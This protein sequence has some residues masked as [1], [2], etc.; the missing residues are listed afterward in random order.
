MDKYTIQDFHKQFPD[1]DACLD[2]LFRRFY[3]NGVICEKCDRETKHYKTAGRPSYQCEFC[4]NHVHPMA[5]TIFE[6]ST[7][8]L[9]LWFYGMYLMAQ[10]RCG[11]SAKQL[12]REL[13]VTYKTAWRMYKQVRSM[14]DEADLSLW[15]SVEIDE[16]YYGGRK[17]GGKRGR[18]A[19]GKTIVAGAVERKGRVV[20][21][22]IP[23]VKATTLVPFALGRVLPASTVYTDELPSYNHLKRHG[24]V[25]RRVHHASR[26]Y[27]DGDAH[28]NSIEGFWSLTK[29]GIGGVYHAVSEK[30]LQS[31]LNEYAFRYNRRNDAEPMFHSFLGRV[32]RPTGRSSALPS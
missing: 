5:G 23:D 8:P 21:R 27:V 13:G 14:L 7:T 1:D 2:W 22:V 32:A 19:P 12:Q 3:P 31:Y 11:I 26:V 6:K 16:S 24:Y 4:G 9:S 20:A 15:G 18:G 17:R 28:T 30:Y 10:T 25:H 29:R